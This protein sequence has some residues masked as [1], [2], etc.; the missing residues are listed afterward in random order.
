MSQHISFDWR[1]GEDE[2]LR[3]AARHFS[4]V[5]QAAYAEAAPAFELSYETLPYAVPSYAVY[6]DAP[7][8]GAPVRDGERA[9]TLFALRAMAALVFVLLAA[10]GASTSPERVDRLAIERE[11][12]VV[13]EMDDA[14]WRSRDREG[15]AALIDPDVGLAWAREW[16]EGWGASVVSRRVHATRLGPAHRVDEDLVQAQVYVSTART[17]WWQAEDLRETRFYRDANGMWL[18]TTPPDS[19]WGEPLTLRTDHFVLRYHAPDAE[20]VE[21]VAPKLDEAYARLY[22]TLALG[23]PPNRRPME[24][25]VHTGL[26]PTRGSSER[27]VQVTSPI[28]AQIP[29]D[30]SNADYLADRI[31][32][33]L[34]SDTLR[35]VSSYGASHRWAFVFSVIRNWLVEDMV[36]LQSH[37]QDEAA[38]VFRADIADERALSLS[39]LDDY[40]VGGTPGRQTV[41]WR[42]AAV[43]SLLDYMIVREGADVLP[44]LVDGLSRTG[45]WSHLVETLFGVSE[46]EFTAG[47]NAYLAAE[48]GPEADIDTSPSVLLMP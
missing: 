7:D 47:W 14:A 48:Y 31:V 10:G 42:Y 22:R 23:A 21:A 26:S 5:H 46:A 12:T 9:L 25:F 19:Y 36:G 40:Y 11:L 3:R 2:Y 29:S 34:V 24:I 15:H 27:A 16:R 35:S 17:N 38:A 32:S 13:L 30:L 44:H 28:L 33:R 37:W 39:D 45:S 8:A 41:L 18:R 20:S 4:A 6:D 1:T 43:G